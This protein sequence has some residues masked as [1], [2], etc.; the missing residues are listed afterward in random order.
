MIFIKKDLWIKNRVLRKEEEKNDVF[1]WYEWIVCFVVMTAL[2][3][4][5]R[6]MLLILQVT[7][8]TKEG[9]VGIYVTLIDANIKSIKI[10][11][12]L[13]TEM[14]VQKENCVII[15]IPYLH[16]KSKWLIKYLNCQGY[17]INLRSFSLVHKINYRY[18]NWLAYV[19][20]ELNII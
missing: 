10:N 18:E 19:S 4:I 1:L 14:K 7:T 6:F 12:F 13:Q 9:I 17:V 5:S 16:Y 3:I 11:L 8:S 2:C 20:L 15:L